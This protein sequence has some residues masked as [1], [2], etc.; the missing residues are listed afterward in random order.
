M[1]GFGFVEFFDIPTAE[2]AVRN[3]QGYELNGRSIRLDYAE[4][5]ND[6]ER[7][8]R[9]G[10]RGKGPGERRRGRLALSNHIMLQGILKV[11][12]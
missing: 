12:T 1:K 3:L 5:F 9:H 2:S 10:T 11:I 4:D 8:I 7:K 6:E